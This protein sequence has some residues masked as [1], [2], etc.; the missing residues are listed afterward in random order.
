[1][2]I[3]DF[4]EI[5]ELHSKSIRYQKKKMDAISLCIQQLKAHKNPY[6]SVSGGKDSVAMAFLVD[7]AAKIAN[8]DFVYWAHISD[9]SFP[10]TKEIIL[11]LSQMTQREVIFSESERS[12]FENLANSKQ[13]RRFGKSGIFYSAVRAFARDK[14][15]SFV[16][17]RAYESKRRMKAAKVNGSTFHSTAMGSVD[18]CYPLLWFRLE[19]VAAT[20]TEYN[21]PIHPIYHKMDVNPSKNA[22]DE[23][24][25][26]RLGYAT[27]RDLMNKGTVLF[28]K[29]NYPD[30]YQKLI[31][32]APEFA[33]Y[34]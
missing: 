19:D 25:W 8:K 1:M 29:L 28:I 14:D 31:S 6:V 34:V 5:G 9:A 16:G 21:A 12:A 22:N 2:N 20:L 24:S 15:L 26:I 4:L 11:K 3:N 33:A 23:E 27:S 17:V 13:K 32:A 7:E 10:G 30:I 18:T